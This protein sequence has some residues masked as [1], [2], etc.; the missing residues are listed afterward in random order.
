MCRSMYPGMLKLVQCL[1]SDDDLLGTGNGNTPS[2]RHSTRNIYLFPEGTLLLAV[3]FELYKG[4]DSKCRQVPRVAT[5][6]RK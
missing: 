2:Y 1:F 3:S 5:P 4:L 6:T